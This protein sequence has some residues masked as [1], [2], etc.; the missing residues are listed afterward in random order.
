MKFDELFNTL[1]EGVYKE[2]SKKPDFPDVDGDGN[3]EEPID[4]AVTD[5]KAKES[6]DDSGDEKKDKDLSKVPPQLRGHIK[7]KK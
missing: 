7:N 5:K 2:K 4:Q 3:T 1:M 6:Q